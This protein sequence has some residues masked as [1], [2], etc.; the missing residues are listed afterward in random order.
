MYCRALQPDW[1]RLHRLRNQVLP[2]TEARV[3]QLAEKA[4]QEAAA[5][6]ELQNE[7]STVQKCVEVGLFFAGVECICVPKKRFLTLLCPRKRLAEKDT[8]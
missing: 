3:A 7:K 1:S 6:G 8:L 5:A 2:E 4:T